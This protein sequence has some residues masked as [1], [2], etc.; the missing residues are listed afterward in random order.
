MIMSWIKISITLGDGY[1]VVLYT[2]TA[3]FSLSMTIVPRHAVLV[4]HVA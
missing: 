2:H 4:R 1:A 3:L